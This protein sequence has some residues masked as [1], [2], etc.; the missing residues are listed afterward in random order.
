MNSFGY[1]G[2]NAHAIL[3]ETS[4][5]LSHR[6]LEKWHRKPSK[7]AWRDGA[8]NYISPTPSRQRIILLSGFDEYSCKANA[9]SLREY[10]LI[11]ESAFDS[12][13]LD[14]V[15][16]TLSEC[17]SR[18]MWKA[19]VTGKSAQDLVDSLSSD[20]KPRISLKRPTL[21][22]IFTGQ[23]AQWT[24]MGKGLLEA[25][26]V[27]RDSVSQIDDYL[28][29]MGASFKA[30]GMWI[31]WAPRGNVLTRRNTQMKS[32]KA[33]KTPSLIALSSAKQCVQLCR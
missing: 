13:L 16:F 11:N 29:E 1:G 28:T 10:I 2:S 30:Y 20:I 3:E 9:K 27:F 21:A 17:R 24:G 4:G 14:D 8:G 19:A 32:P 15:A 7:A 6:G 12:G 25:Y 26:S 22:F 23:G 5:Y 31:F 18:F 33:L